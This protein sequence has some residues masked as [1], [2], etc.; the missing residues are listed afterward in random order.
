MTSKKDMN[1]KLADYLHRRLQ[2]LEVCTSE[3]ENKLKD[4]KSSLLDDIDNGVR[5]K[6]DPDIGK[7]VFHLNY[8]VGNTF[9]YTM[10]VGICSFVEEALKA[11]AKLLFSDYESQFKNLRKGSEIDKHIKLLTRDEKFDAASIQTD[12]DKFK[13]MYTLR[14]CIVHAWGKLENAKVPD[15]VTEALARIE[16]AE[17]SKDGYLLLGDQV[18]AEAIDTAESIV[19]SVITQRMGTSIT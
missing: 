9:R 12:L 19:D 8:V 15:D 18:I 16:T 6:N 1:K 10:L 5:D 4:D 17:I 2:Y 11:I 7:L 14:N 13:D 3:I